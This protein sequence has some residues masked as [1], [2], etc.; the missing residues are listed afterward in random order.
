M[1]YNKFID[2]NTLNQI[3]AVHRSTDPEFE[4][5]YNKFFDKIKDFPADT[6]YKSLENIVL[7]SCAT[8]KMMI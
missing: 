1:E 7:M 3:M 2:D 5:K 4:R 8:T 6:L